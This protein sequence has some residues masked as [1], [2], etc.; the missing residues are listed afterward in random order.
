[1]FP[2]GHEVFLQACCVENVGATRGHNPAVVAYEMDV[3]IRQYSPNDV[4]D[5][6][7]NCCV[8][9]TKVAHNQAG[10]HVVME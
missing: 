9:A 3:N 1:M 7:E 6:P 4:I 2:I 10:V 8:V 5:I